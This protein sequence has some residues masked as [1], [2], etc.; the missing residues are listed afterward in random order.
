MNISRAPRRPRCDDATVPVDIPA[1]IVCKRC[2]GVAG[3]KIAGFC[4]TSRRAPTPAR[5]WRGRHQSKQQR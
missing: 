1:A 3:G 4:V 5:E 2:N